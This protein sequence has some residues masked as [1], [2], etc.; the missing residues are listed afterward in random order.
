MRPFKF[1][2][3]GRIGSGRQWMSWIT[4]LDVVSVIRAVLENTAVSGA[5]YGVAPPTPR[6]AGFAPALG[7]G[8]HPPAVI[9]APAFSPQFAPCE[10]ADALLPAYPPLAPVPLQ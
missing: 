3:G 8:D 10:K 6:N 2:M 1:G 7:R 4:L 5:V 9:A